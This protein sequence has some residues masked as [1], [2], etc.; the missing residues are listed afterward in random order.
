[1]G[2]TRE[3]RRAG[4]DYLDAVTA[5]LR[6]NRRLHPTMG[7]FEAAELQFQWG[8]KRAT[9]DLGQLFWF[10]ELGRPE[11][12]AIINSFSRWI[13]FDPIVLP[14]AT[15]DRV[16]H[17]IG[18]GLAH[19]DESGFDTVRLEVDRDDDASR[20]VLVER[21]FAIEEDGQIETWLAADARPDVSPLH[22][23]YR[24]ASRLETS[25]H[26]HHMAKRGGPDV[27]QRFHQTS[28]Y[29]ADL[30][31]VVLD[32]EGAHAANGLFWYD[33]E[34]AIGVVE[35]MRT[36]DDHRRRGLARR[37]LTAGIDRLV[38]AGATRIKICFEPENVA[39]RRLYL[40]VGFVP[41]KQTDVYAGPTSG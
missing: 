40:D 8:V 25:T 38:E 35:P 13:Q 14:G 41:V 33:P 3:E 15:P 31:L 32:R 36:E 17:V 7:L 10:D 2:T 37:I 22:D 6:R 29:R 39:A 26:P 18:R 20:D 27:E 34:L 23:D 28:L 9:D 21:G 12:A 4:V 30:D 11:A 5:L 16:A 24:L 19:A 1:M